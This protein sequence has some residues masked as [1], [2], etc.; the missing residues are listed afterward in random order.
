MFFFYKDIHCALFVVYYDHKSINRKFFKGFYFLILMVSRWSALPSVCR[1]L[2]ESC[3][4]LPQLL[5][6]SGLCQRWDV[7]TCC[8][9]TMVGAAVRVA[10]ATKQQHKS[11]SLPA[12]P[13]FFSFPSGLIPHIDWEGWSTAAVLCPRV[14]L[15]VSVQ[16]DDLR[17][18]CWQ[19]LGKSSFLTSLFC[20]HLE[21]S[22]LDALSING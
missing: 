7:E 2:W 9:S 16:H 21:W 1:S 15:L 18:W 22:Q 6:L 14:P 17:W 5:S 12:A 20:Y 11:P 4:K 13:L 3:R 10:L 19:Q 8:L